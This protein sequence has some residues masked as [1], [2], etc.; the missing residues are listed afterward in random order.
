MVYNNYLDPYQQVVATPVSSNESIYLAPDEN[1]EYNNNNIII[2]FNGKGVLDKQHPCNFDDRILFNEKKIESLKISAI[3]ISYTDDFIEGLQIAYEA[4]N[5]SIIPGKHNSIFIKQSKNE[6]KM[7][8]QKNEAVQKEQQ[9]SKKQPKN[10]YLLKEDV[11]EIP[12]D[13]Y[14]VEIIGR[15]SE[16]LNYI[17]FVTQKGETS[18]MFGNST[19]GKPFNLQKKGYTFGASK[20]I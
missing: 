16:F 17:Q 15:K 19:L 18:S 1:G 10:C 4:N 8:N 3:K 20:Y 9:L 7:Q 2:Q 6:K 13:D 11:F 14:I 12:V 5:G